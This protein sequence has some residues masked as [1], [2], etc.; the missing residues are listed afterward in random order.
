MTK[1]FRA[2]GGVVAMDRFHDTDAIHL[3]EARRRLAANDNRKVISIGPRNPQNSG[4]AELRALKSLTS[5]AS[6]ILT[7]M[8]AAVYVI[9]VSD[10]KCV[11]IGKATSPAKRLA[12]LQTGNHEPLF[13]HRVFW[14][15]TV[16]EADRVEK[17]AHEYSG[18]DSIRLEGEWFECSPYQAHKSIER[19]L[20]HFGS[21]YCVLTP[22]LEEVYDAA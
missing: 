2:P 12:T 21:H 14:V 11:K 4:I 22:A 16:R 13:L 20:D 1:D 19:A 7:V 15:P 10:A 17:L 5:T 3:A 8:K 18:T 6:E 9:G